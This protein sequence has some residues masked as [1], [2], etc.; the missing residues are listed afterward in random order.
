MRAFTRAANPTPL[1]RARAR[2]GR[3][4]Y[5]RAVARAEQGDVHGR[6]D[7]ASLGRSLQAVAYCLRQLG[8]QADA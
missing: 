8:R 5:E 2:W 1:A 4:W 3:P 6:V 7:H